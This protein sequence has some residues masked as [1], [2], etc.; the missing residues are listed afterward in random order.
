MDVENDEKSAAGMVNRELSWKED[1]N[2]GQT[3]ANKKKLRG[4][5]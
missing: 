2:E 3:D 4:W 5:G 1:K